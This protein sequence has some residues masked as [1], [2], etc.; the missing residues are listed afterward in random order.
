MRAFSQWVSDSL[1]EVGRAAAMPKVPIPRGFSRGPLPAPL[2]IQA[3]DRPNPVSN[4]LRSAKAAQ[5]G[6]SFLRTKQQLE[7]TP[8]SARL[9]QAGYVAFAPGCAQPQ[10]KEASTFLDTSLYRN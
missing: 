9:S 3:G 8:Q 6:K 2:G 4:V 10:A 7:S 5:F 1:H